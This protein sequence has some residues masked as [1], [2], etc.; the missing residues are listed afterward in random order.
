MDS[1]KPADKGLWDY[2]SD[3]MIFSNLSIAMILWLAIGFGYYL[4]NFEIKYMPGNLY[5]NVLM[6]TA[7]EVFAKACACS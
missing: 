7:A 4:I 5:V 6:A 3:S 1:T 2:L